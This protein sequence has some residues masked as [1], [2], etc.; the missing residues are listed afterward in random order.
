MMGGRHIQAVLEINGGLA[1]KLGI[2]AGSQ[3]RHP[4]F[5]ADRAAWP[6]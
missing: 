2:A 4:A 1:R 3:M 5:D 6:C